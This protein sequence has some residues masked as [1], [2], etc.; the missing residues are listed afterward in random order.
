M[1]IALSKE[2]SCKGHLPATVGP[3]V[4]ILA[5]L[6]KDLSLKAAAGADGRLAENG[7][8]EVLESTHEGVVGEEA[9]AP[10]SA[11]WTT[12]DPVD[13]TRMAFTNLLAGSLAHLFSNGPI[14]SDLTAPPEVNQPIPGPSMGLQGFVP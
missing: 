3:E 7:E 14:S 6:M 5:K 10:S 1:K 9:E 2:T 12:S 11:S 8:N 13:V 4:D